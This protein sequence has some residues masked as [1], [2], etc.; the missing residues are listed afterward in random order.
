MT[1]GRIGLPELEVLIVLMFVFTGAIAIYFLP[2]IVAV[3]RGKRNR[4]S[5]IMVNV[6]LGWTFIGWVV[7]LVWAFATDTVDVIAV[8]QV[9]SI[10]R[11]RG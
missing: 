6:L 9:A 3:K 4:T 7:A 1:M 5:I 2:T 8:P 11:R 10:G